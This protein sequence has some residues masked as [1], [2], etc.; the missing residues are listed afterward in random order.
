MSLLVALRLTS[1]LN[2]TGVETECDWCVS[3]CEEVESAS[4]GS[5]PQNS[6]GATNV[7]ACL[8]HPCFPQPRSIEEMR[9]ERGIEIWAAA[10]VGSREK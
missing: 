6:M 2:R 4:R 1:L 10:D 3:H 8:S 5:P 7:M 9:P